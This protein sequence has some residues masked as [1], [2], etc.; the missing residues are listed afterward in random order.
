MLN[1]RA[2]VHFQLSGIGLMQ[3]AEVALPRSLATGQANC[4][5]VQ[6]KKFGRMQHCLGMLGDYWD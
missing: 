3:H 2:D 4:I 1:E 5:S 6:T